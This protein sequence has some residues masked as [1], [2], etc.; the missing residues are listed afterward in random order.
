MSE[1][2]H[3]LIIDDL[4]GR[5]LPGRR[6]VE[7]ANLC[8]Q[9]LLQDATGDEERLESGQRIKRPIAQAV[10]CRG[11]RPA[12]ASIGDMV[13][14]DLDGTLR[15]VREGWETLPDR[16]AWALVLLDLCFY[17]GRVTEASDRRASGM[18]E[19]RR[20]DDNPQHYFGLTLLEALHA[21]FPDLPV[22]MLSSHPREEV[23]HAFTR[24]GALGFLAREA[25]DSP[26]RLRDY[27]FRHGLLPDDGG[28]IVGRSRPLLLALR[29]ARRAAG[30]RKNLLIHGERGSGKELL[31]RYAHRQGCRDGVSRPLITVNSGALS[32]EL[33]A[34]TLFGHEKGA[35]TTAVAAREG[36]IVQA[37][38]GDLFLDEIGNMPPDVQ[39]GLLRVLEY[40]E[41]E[42]LGAHSTR[43]VDVRCLS[44]TNDDLE[45]RA[46]WGDFRADLLDRLRLGG[47]VFLPPLRERPEDLP[48]LVEKAVRDAEA[49]TP[50]SLRRDLDPKTIEL[51]ASYDW[52]GNVRELVA[53]VGQAVK[54]NPD[55]E[56]L[57]PL[58][59]RLPVRR[60]PDRPV[61]PG[62][63]PVEAAAPLPG[64][65]DELTQALTAL[66][67]AAPRAEELTGRLPALQAAF[68]GLVARYVRAALEVTCRTRP[69]EGGSVQREIL[70]HP[71]MKLI[72]GNPKLTASRAA[73]L[74]KRLLGLSPEE[75]APLLEEPLLKD[76]Y[77]KALDLRPRQPRRTSERKDQDDPPLEQS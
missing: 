66:S 72:T 28:D 15:I 64:S 17:T 39:A 68:A 12:S 57:V 58:H 77:A 11:Q 52:P 60:G 4:F 56:H 13:E 75:I 34:S 71:A 2:P 26:E 10:F 40:G 37:H 42:P 43:A 16:P 8:G 35:F 46:A 54:E 19:G 76:A 70:I 41:V 7:R 50:G 1:L 69:G 73:D 3:L 25:A 62:S 53:C 30:D 38:G 5:S 27:L 49:S 61:A 48:L 9:F 6:N 31:A 59:V 47:T 23:S 36:A 24:A 18:P 51:L 74:I 44:A 32:R 55:V 45:A 67:F 65:L 14:N 29:A 63:G 22:V 21:A 20:G 33:Y